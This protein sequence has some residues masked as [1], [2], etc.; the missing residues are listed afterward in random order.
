[1]LPRWCWLITSLWVVSE[2]TNTQ[3]KRRTQQ[4]NARQKRHTQTN[5]H[6][7]KK[8]NNNTRRKKNTGF[9]FG[10]GSFVVFVKLWC[11]AHL[12]LSFSRAVDAS[13]N[14]NIKQSKQIFGDADIADVFI[15]LQQNLRLFS[16][17]FFRL[18]IWLFVCCM[19]VLHFTLLP[20]LFWDFV[21]L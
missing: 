10:A 16:P 21:V 5:T 12:S 8:K 4:K 6:K 7:L 14:N 2:P 19:F 9:S 1:M 3:T 18:F 11:F 17:R 15:K 13:Y 20:I